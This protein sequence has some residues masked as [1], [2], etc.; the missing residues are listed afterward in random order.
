MWLW[1]LDLVL[2]DSKEEIRKSDSEEPTD[3]EHYMN[4]IDEMEKHVLKNSVLH[5]FDLVE[6]VKHKIVKMSHE[7]NLKQLWD[8]MMDN[9]LKMSALESEA[10]PENKIPSFIQGFITYSDFLEFFI[11]NY[12]GDI[13]PFERTINELDFDYARTRGSQS[14]D[15]TIKVIQKDEKLYSVLKKMLDYRIGMAPIVD[16]MKS[17]KTIGFFFLKDVFWLLRSG[18]FEFLDKS[19]LLLLKTIYQEGQEGVSLPSEEE[20]EEF[21]G[22]SFDNIDKDQ[23]ELFLEQLDEE[24]KSSRS[25]DSKYRSQSYALDESEKSIP[26]TGALDYPNKESSASQ[27]NLTTKVSKGKLSEGVQKRQSECNSLGKSKKQSSVSDKMNSENLLKNHS[28][29]ELKLTKKRTNDPSGGSMFKRKNRA[30]SINSFTP[31]FYSKRLVPKTREIYGI[32]RIATFHRDWTLKDCI[33]KIMWV[34]E[35]KLVEMD[36]ELRVVAVLTLSDLIS[37]FSK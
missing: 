5:I 18:K 33:E 24:E 36:S 22:E 27:N 3:I 11:D 1:Y 8:V 4:I 37:Y 19:V 34:P 30:H 9:N 20:E 29:T 31:E 23:E 26:T 25:F 21:E 35:N 14:D 32:N 13:R 15:T 2:E 6:G 7:A 12:E 28:S 17:K 10:D 16:N